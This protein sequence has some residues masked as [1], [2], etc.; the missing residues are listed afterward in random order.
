M[1]EVFFASFDNIFILL[2]GNTKSSTQ[3]A[4]KKK[5]DP[6]LD[7]EGLTVYC[8]HQWQGKAP[9]DTPA[10]MACILKVK[11][12]RKTDIN[13]VQEDIV[14]AL[15]AAGVIVSKE[16]IK[17][18]DARTVHTGKDGLI[19]NLKQDE[20]DI[21]AATPAP[22]VPSTSAIAAAENAL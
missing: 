3:A 1:K 4:S 11:G 9:L 18:I 8:R 15:L 13:Q 10:V 5:G 20:K 2:R 6:V 16:V 19:F 7:Q 22:A 21:K 17:N 12:N 14:G